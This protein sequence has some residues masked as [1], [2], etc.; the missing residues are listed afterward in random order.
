MTPIELMLEELESHQLMVVLAPSKRHDAREWDMIRCLLDQ[1]P[2]WYRQFCAN[3][4]SSRGVRR[5]K[6][7]TRIKR[8]NVLRALRQIIAGKPAGKYEDELRAIGAKYGKRLQSSLTNP[9]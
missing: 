9:F 3:H 7:D 8:A 6:F 1:N 4:S 2:L 5:G